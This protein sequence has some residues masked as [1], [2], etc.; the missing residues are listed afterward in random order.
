MEQV[1]IGKI[2][3]TVGLRGEVKVFVTTDFPVQRFKKGRKVTLLNEETEESLTSIIVSAR[4]VKDRFVV[5]FDNINIIEEADKMIGFLILI[6]KQQDELPHGYFFHDDLIGC[7]T[8]DEENNLIGIVYKIE[9]YPAHR[10]LRIKRQESPDVLVPFIKAFIKSVNM[11]KREII[12][13]V[14]EGML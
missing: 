11:E 2:I 6:E 13:K 1:S 10:T 7:S 14:I 4:K 5:T 12:I 3:G 8:I 9:D